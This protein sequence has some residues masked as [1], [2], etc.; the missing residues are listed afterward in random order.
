MRT[1]RRVALQFAAVIGAIGLVVASPGS[2]QAVSNTIYTN[3]ADPGGRMWLN[4]SD[5]SQ[6]WFVAWV[7]DQQKDGYSVVGWLYVDGKRSARARD[8]TGDDQYC[9]Y[10]TNFMKIRPGQRYTLKVCLQDFSAGGAPRFCNVESF[11][12]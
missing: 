1:L 3:D 11:R 6:G 10:S 8:S 7:C 9:G 12:R 4:E 5:G 2:A